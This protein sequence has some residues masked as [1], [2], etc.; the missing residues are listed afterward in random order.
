MK[1]E[2]SIVV[3][4]GGAGGIGRALAHA[5]AKARHV[6]VADI[7]EV[8]AQRT[9]NEI[10]GTVRAVDVSREEDIAALIGETGYA[11]GPIGL[12]CGNAGIFVPGGV[13]VPDADWERIW[14]IN[15]M[16]HIWT[17]RHLFPRMAARGGGH[18]LITASA[19]G[20]LSQ[21][22]S[23]PYAVTKHGAVAAAE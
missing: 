15:V 13:D 19:A 16:A 11:V 3:V 5:A 17:A 1:V 23:A 12:F 4:T 2:G 6:V 20:L 7:D 21:V 22:G 18:V 8:G 14:K 10:G 9:A